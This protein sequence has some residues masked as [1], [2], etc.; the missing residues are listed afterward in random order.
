MALQRVSWTGTVPMEI[1]TMSLTPTG[2]DLQFTRPVDKETVGRAASYSI[3]CYGYDYNGGYGSPP[4]GIQAVP[5]KK[6]EV[7]A[8]GRRVSLTLSE[9]LVGKVYEL[10]IKGVKS[11]DGVELLHPEAYYTVNR[12]R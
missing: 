3:Q 7:S 10:H 2:F 8:D 12:L 9:V 11:V 5:V 1:A 4:S 6:A